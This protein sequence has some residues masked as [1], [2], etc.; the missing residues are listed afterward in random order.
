MGGDAGPRGHKARKECHDPPLSALDGPRRAVHTAI[1][2]YCRRQSAPCMGRVLR[3]PQGWGRRLD[4]MRH[5]QELRLSPA[6][7]FA[8]ALSGPVG[9][10]SA[11][12]ARLVCYAPHA[13]PGD[14]ATTH[15]VRSRHTSLHRSTLHSLHRVVGCARIP[16]SPR[17]PLGLFAPR[18]HPVTRYAGAVSDREAPGAPYLVAA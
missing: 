13:A 2:P 10:T 12:L 14:G 7:R 4:G 17:T 3:A 6:L 1:P 5:G 18:L 11:G 9:V 15:R 16:A 8:P